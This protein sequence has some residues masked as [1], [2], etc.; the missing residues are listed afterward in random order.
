LLTQCQVIQDCGK[1]GAQ[2]GRQSMGAELYIYKK[3][4]KTIRKEHYLK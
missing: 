1:R 3:T 4:E 2:Q